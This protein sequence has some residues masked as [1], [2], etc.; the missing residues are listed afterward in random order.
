MHMVHMR[1]N[2]NTHKTKIMY[3]KKRAT[4]GVAGRKVSGTMGERN[5][6]LKAQK[7]YEIVK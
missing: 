7:M 6:S 1:A 4:W 5:K 2:I 3:F